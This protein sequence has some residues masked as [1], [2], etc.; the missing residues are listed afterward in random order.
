[1]VKNRKRKRRLNPVYWVLQYFS[2][3][4]AI[5]SFFWIPYLVNM[6]LGG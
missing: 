2:C 6:I 4:V 5:S 1:M 3:I